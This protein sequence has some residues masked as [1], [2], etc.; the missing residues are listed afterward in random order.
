MDDPLKTIPTLRRCC[1]IGSRGRMGGLFVSRLQATGRQ[2]AGLDQPLE[3]Q[4]LAEVLPN[5]DLVLLAVPAPV[6]EDVLARCAAHLSPETV[7]MDICSVKVLPM[8]VML[9]YHAGSVVGTH[10]LFGPEPNQV[11]R[12]AVTPGRGEQALNAILD[13]L[14]KLGFAPFLSTAETHDRAMAAVQGLNFV[15]T[16]AYLSALAEDESLESFLTPSFSRRLEAAR[17][18]LTEDATMFTDLFEANPYSQDAVRL[19]RSHLNLAAGG[20]MDVL[21]QRAGWWWRDKQIRG[22][23]GP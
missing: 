6:L 4:R 10:P 14:T 1:V 3:K 16:C 22:T 12:V 23:T 5:Q 9:R 11:A 20:D 21:A 7:L 18:M 15:T 19:F 8:A 17:K 2:V 13:L